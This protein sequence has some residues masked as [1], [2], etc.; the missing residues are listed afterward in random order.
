[1][2]AE[3]F[4]ETLESYHITTRCHKPED[5]DLNLIMRLEFM[6]N[7]AAFLPLFETNII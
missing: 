2:V 5:H 6:Y 3:M 7:M 1:M 4:S